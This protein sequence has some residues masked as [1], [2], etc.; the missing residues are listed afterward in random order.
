MSL[1]AT[2]RER[3]ILDAKISKMMDD[4]PLLMEARRK[5]WQLARTNELLTDE[6]QQGM[7]VNY[8][9][10]MMEPMDQT[11]T[12]SIGEAANLINELCDELEIAYGML[13]EA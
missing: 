4:L 6:Y 12:V 1:I 9:G 10:K 5:C 7:R 13:K 2:I 3:A 11:F 8:G